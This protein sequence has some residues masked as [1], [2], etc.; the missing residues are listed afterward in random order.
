MKYLLLEQNSH[1]DTEIKLYKT[2]P[3][4]ILETEV[5]T[6]TENNRRTEAA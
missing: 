4:T 2:I 6:V 1:E 3:R 5:C